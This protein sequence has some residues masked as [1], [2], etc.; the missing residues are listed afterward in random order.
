MVPFVVVTLPSSILMGVS[1]VLFVVVIGGTA[2]VMRASSGE[3]GGSGFT[4]PCPL[5]VVA[6]C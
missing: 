3:E 1:E 6:V 5:V 2:L 4:G